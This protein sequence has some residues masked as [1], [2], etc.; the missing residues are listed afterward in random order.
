MQNKLQKKER[1][2]NDL[3]AEDL[4][5]HRVTFTIE[6]IGPEILE[7]FAKELGREPELLG[8]RLRLFCSTHNHK[9]DVVLYSLPVKISKTVSYERI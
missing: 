8:S 1:I 7:A 9:I 6:D 4:G 3:L 2:G 5:L